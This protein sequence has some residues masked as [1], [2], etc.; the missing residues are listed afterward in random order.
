MHAVLLKSLAVA[1]P[2]ELYRLGKEARC[3][4][5]GWVQPGQ[6]VFARLLRFVQTLQGQHPRLCGTGGVPGGRSARSA[7]GAPARAEAAQSYPGEYVS[8]NYFAMFG[9]KAYA[10]RMLTAERRS[11]RR[12]ARRGDELS[13]MA[14]K[15]WVGP[16]VIGGAFN[17][18]DKPFTVVGITPPGFFGDTLRNIPPDFF[19]PLNTEPSV[20]GDNDLNQP[21]THWLDL[22]GRIQPGAR[23]AS[24]EAEMRVEL[25]Q[26]LRSHWG[27]M[28][29]NDRATFPE[30]TLFLTSRRRGHH[31]HARAI[32]ALASNPDDGLRICAAHRLRQR[33]QSHACSRYGA[34]A[35][36]LV[37]HG[38]GGAGVAAGEAGAH[39]K[40]PALHCWAARRASRLH[41]P[42]RA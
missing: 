25:K 21:D 22:I 23:P 32:R 5:W 13:L 30:Q 10:G 2:A 18:D 3:C 36:D 33:R 41:L 16:A 7:S 29:A 11:T 9:I 39:R 28:S 31:Q 12:S 34:A 20:D 42:A 8:G 6:R 19:L 40:H 38:A 1:N 14:A 26:W 27:E 37:E 17:L 24:I 4:Y 15:V 35:A